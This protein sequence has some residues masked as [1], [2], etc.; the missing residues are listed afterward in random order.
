MRKAKVASLPNTSTLTGLLEEYQEMLREAQRR[1]KKALTLDG[2]DEAFWEELT[3]LSPLLTMVEAR[4]SGIQEE[5]DKLIEE[6]P[7]D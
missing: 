3:R 1:V 7:E 5:I 4:S 2:S 6:L